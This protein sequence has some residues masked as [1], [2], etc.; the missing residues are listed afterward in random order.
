MFDR[1]LIETFATG[2]D[3]LR[4]AIQGLSREQLLAFPVPG[5]W[6]IQQ[7]VVHLLDS[8]IVGVDR[9][10]RIAALENPLLIGFDESAYVRTL[11]PEDQPLEQV[12]DMLELN[13][14]LWAITLR[15]L[16]DDAFDRTGVHNE[17]GRVTLGELVR[18]YNDHLQHHL[19]FIARK[20][21][22]VGG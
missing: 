3:Q 12:L 7:I 11:R 22:M 16:P 13:R 21:A 10:K 6:S 5:T 17:R 18:D 14:R 2:G 19:G 20:R 4:R 9:M 15:A 8:E 1:T